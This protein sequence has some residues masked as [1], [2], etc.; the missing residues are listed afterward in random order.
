[1]TR[2]T[3]TRSRPV[4]AAGLAAVLLGA[5][6]PALA[7]PGPRGTVGPA[8]AGT[9]REGSVYATVT[10]DGVVLGN[11]LAERR[12]SRAA[13]RTTAL[14]DKRGQDRTWSAGSRDFSLQVGAASVGSELFRVAS[15]AVTPL[16]RGGLR[17]TMTLDG[18]PG[19]AATREVEAYD[20][21]AGFR[22]RTV[23]HPTAPLV[24]RGATLDEVAVGTAAPTLHALRA[25]ADWREP[26]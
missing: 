1:M 18:V 26:G 22:T 17:V 12:W 25:G 19:L 2:R 7:A 16:D 14:V 15:V 21:V 8:P 20:G 4:L 9:T 5:V 24:L 6:A 13:L 10:A 3:W 23:L 11:A